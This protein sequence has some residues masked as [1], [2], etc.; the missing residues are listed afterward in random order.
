MKGAESAG[1]QVMMSAQ[2][3]RFADGQKAPHCRVLQKNAFN[4]Q[5]ATP[6][7]FADKTNR[8]FIELFEFYGVGDMMLKI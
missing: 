4:L 3:L 8:L 6:Q 2:R 7:G 5:F 1:Y